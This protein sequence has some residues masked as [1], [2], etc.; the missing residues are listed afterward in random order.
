MT[1]STLKKVNVGI[2]A[3]KAQLDVCI[4]ETQQQVSFPNTPRGIRQLSLL[5][6]EFDVDR[7]VIE[8]TGRLERPLL[9]Y[10]LWRRGEQRKAVVI[11]HPYE[12]EAGSTALAALG[13]RPRQTFRHMR[14]DLTGG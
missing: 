11:E 1:R 4:H 2:D 5:L 6:C 3:G 14:H 9:E 8:A 12:D 13:F 7:I 10:A